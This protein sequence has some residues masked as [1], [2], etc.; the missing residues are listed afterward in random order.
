MRQPKDSTMR[1][2]PKLTDPK[3]GKQLDV[4]DVLD[5]IANEPQTTEVE[6]RMTVR[7]LVNARMKGLA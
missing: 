6:D 4:Y 7:D 1:Q 2:T 3:F 5:D